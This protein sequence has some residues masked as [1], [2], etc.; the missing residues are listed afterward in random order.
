M[1]VDLPI[2]SAPKIP[3]NCVSITTSLN[4]DLVSTTILIFF[5]NVIW[6][7]GSA[8]FKNILLIFEEAFQSSKSLTVLMMSKNSSLL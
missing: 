2:S 6:V 5:R 1:K 4:R 8:C 7:T 3:Q